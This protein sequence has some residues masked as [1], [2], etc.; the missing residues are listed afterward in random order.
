MQNWATNVGTQKR[1]RA[2]L[3]RAGAKTFLILA[4]TNA[5]RGYD[6]LD[7]RFDSWPAPSIALLNENWVGEL[8]AMPV[9][10]G[11]TGEI[12]PPLKLKGAAEALLYLVPRDSL[13]RVSAARAEVDDTS[14]EKELLRRMTI[15]GFYP[16]Y[17]RVQGEGAVQ[18]TVCTARTWQRSAHDISSRT[19]K[20]G[21]AT[22][23]P[24]AHF[25]HDCLP[26]SLRGQADTP[27]QSLEARVRA[28]VINPQ[29]SFEV[30]GEVQGLFLVGFF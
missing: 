16:C 24:K 17:P 25:S 8:S 23:S 13:I 7:H 18:R 30:P 1:P 9:I 27:K 11:G 14:Y 6:D 15:L 12:K 21:R 4:G 10:T 22:T 3:R 5:V 26:G 29:I 2:E 20:H 28:E 19:K